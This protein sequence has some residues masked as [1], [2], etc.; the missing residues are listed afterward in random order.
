MLVSVPSMQSM[1]I[2]SIQMR[3]PIF[4]YLNE[5]NGAPSAVLTGGN[6]DHI[7]ERIT[8]V[9]GKYGSTNGFGDFL[10]MRI[11]LRVTKEY[12]YTL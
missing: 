7:K 6:V 8:V 11:M 9:F 10:P 12:F 2:S 1:K 3:R 4:P 5:K